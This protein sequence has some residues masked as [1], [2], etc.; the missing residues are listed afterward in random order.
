M[1]QEEQEFL[2]SVATLQ[3][4]SGQTLD[5]NSPAIYGRPYGYISRLACSFIYLRIF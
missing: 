5:I 1:G 2:H 4:M 3:G